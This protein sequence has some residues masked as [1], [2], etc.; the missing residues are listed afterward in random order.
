M[1]H[2]DDEEVPTQLR[3]FAERDEHEW[4]PNPVSQIMRQAADLIERLS[5]G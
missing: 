1:E 4:G 2:P 5:D 3:Y